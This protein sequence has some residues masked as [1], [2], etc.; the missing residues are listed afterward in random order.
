MPKQNEVVLVI[1]GKPFK[2]TETGNER[3]ILESAIYVSNQAKTLAP[4]DLGQLR[5][6]VMYKTGTKQKGG[7]N[8]SSGEQAELEIQVEPK[9]DEAFVGS[10]LDYATY[11]EFGTRTMNAQPF[12]R[13]AVQ[14]LNLSDI[15][16]IYRKE[17]TK[18]LREGKKIIKFSSVKGSF[19]NLKG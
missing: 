7:F 5:N 8:N 19:A 4:V 13:P 15:A 1:N 14:T 16:P 10:N 9:K 12:L 2:G 11:Q 17:M 6:S 18:A 3:G